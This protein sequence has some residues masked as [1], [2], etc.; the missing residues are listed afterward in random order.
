[1]FDFNSIEKYKFSVRE[2]RLK[3]DKAKEL[4]KTELTSEEK[5]KV[6]MSLLA[7]LSFLNSTSHTKLFNFLDQL[8]NGNFSQSRYKKYECLTETVNEILLNGTDYIDNQYLHLLLQLTNNVAMPYLENTDYLPMNI[9]DEQ[10]MQVATSF[11]ASLGD[12]ELNTYFQ[13]IASRPNSITIT[14]NMRTGNDNFRGICNYDYINNEPYITV[15]KTDDMNDLYILSHEVMHGIDF[16][17]KPKLYSETYYGFHETPTYA[18][19]YLIA[20][21]LESIG[22]DKLEVDKMRREKTAYISGLASQ[23]QLQI[24]HRLR[25]KGIDVKN[26]YSIDDVKQILDSSIMKN[27]LEIE[28][29]I[30]AYGFY[31]QMQ[32]DKHQG[33]DNLKR[34]MKSNIPKNK[35]PDFSQYGL[36]NEVLLALSEQY[37]IDIQQ[38]RQNSGE[39]RTQ[40]NNL[41]NV[42]VRK[43]VKPNRSSAFIKNSFLLIIIFSFSIIMVIMILAAKK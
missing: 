37:S 9:S 25:E 11:Y 36:S 29:G 27:L 40:E 14:S 7:Y 43:L 8:T 18:I 32:I 16:L 42:I 5:E 13:Q 31:Q 3:I 33:L 2:L 26:G 22:V 21:Y 39:N 17:M 19:E 6:E 4:L 24:K 20:D 15:Y 12:S 38:A 41:S 28:S 1:M 10:M 35:I 23:T 34:F 30:M